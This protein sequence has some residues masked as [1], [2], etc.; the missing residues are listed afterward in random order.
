MT[1]A[2]MLKTNLPQNWPGELEVLG[3]LLPLKHAVT[4]VDPLQYR[5]GVTVGFDGEV[6]AQAEPE[7]H[8]SVLTVKDRQSG[9]LKEARVKMLPVPLSW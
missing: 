5:T 8:D 1:S 3:Q 7:L 4:G 9:I 6:K 2:S